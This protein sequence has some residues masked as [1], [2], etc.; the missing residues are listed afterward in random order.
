MDQTCEDVQVRLMMGEPLPGELAAHLKGCSNC[1]KASELSSALHGAFT[2]GPD[3]SPG[4]RVLD[5]YELLEQIGRGGQ[6]AVFKARDLETGLIVAL[7][8]VALDEHSVDE[9][10]H[11][12]GITHPNVCRTNHTKTCGLF[13]VIVM[14]FVRGPTLRERLAQGPIAEKQAIAVFRGICQGVRAAH[15]RD[16]VHLD[17]KPGNVLLRDGFVPVVTDFGLASVTGSAPR[18]GTEGYMAPE[19]ERGERLDQRTDVFA[20]G[21][22][23]RELVP[24]PSPHL[25]AVIQQAC[26]ESVEQRPANVDEL[27]R[28]VDEALRSDALPVAAVAAADVASN[29]A[30]SVPVGPQVGSTVPPALPTRAGL[31]IL[32]LVLVPVLILA[33]H[34]LLLGA[35]GVVAPVLLVAA[36]VAA[37]GVVMGTVSL[38]TRPSSELAKT[39]PFKVV[40][41]VL[42]LGELVGVAF[43]SKDWAAHR[44]IRA[45]VTSADPC[46]FDRVTG[47][48]TEYGNDEERAQLA[49]RKAACAEANYNTNCEAVAAHLD[50]KRV[51]DGDLAFIASHSPST[52]MEGVVSRVASG[53]LAVGDLGRAKADLPCGDR[54]WNRLVEAAAATPVAW[55]LGSGVPR[56]SDDMKA[57]LANTTLSVDVQGAIQAGE[58]AVVQPVLRKTRTNDMSEGESLCELGTTLHVAPSAS[59]V[60]LGKRYLQARAREDAAAAAKQTASAAQDARCQALEAARNNCL[61]PCMTFD[62]FD[63]RADSCEAACERRFPK[64]S[65]E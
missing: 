15:E 35:A 42:A 58:D 28:L 37:A 57:A 45:V 64:K 34:A 19:Q 18:G 5:Q 56:I 3:W 10:L 43:G 48:L 11:A 52:P 31:V 46:D 41:V 33:V 59:C 29:Q 30:R 2:A 47:D 61:V 9:V 27:L 51:T 63:P 13:R 14:E 12:S 6:G 50:A 60:A 23:L 40:L 54:I 26:A 32:A 22:M 17:L 49:S 8:V 44:R 4:E 7:K 62:L 20:L 38:R 55:S 24:S 16:V 39:T 36:G 53:K 1:R 65:C 21:V 25:R